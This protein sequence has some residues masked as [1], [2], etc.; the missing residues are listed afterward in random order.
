MKPRADVLLVT[1]TKVETEAVLQAAR[2][3]T[4]REPV[5][6]PIDAKT[7]FDLGSIGGARVCWSARKWAQAV[8]GLLCRR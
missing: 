4:G 2:E 8:W 1:V 7:Y 3:Q 5:L 6:Q